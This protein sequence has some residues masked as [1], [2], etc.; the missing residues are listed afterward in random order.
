M[1]RQA[2]IDEE[3]NGRISKASSAFGR[4][5]RNVWDRRGIKLSTKLKVYQA[6]VITTLLYACETWTVYR[7]HAKQLNHFHTTCLRRLL[8]IHWQDHTP[9]TEVLSR[10]N[11]PS[12]H[13]LIEKAQA[14]WAGHVRR[15]ND[16]RIPKMLLY[17]E[18]A[19][20]KRLAGRPKLRFK[21]SLKATLKSL[22]I[23]VENWEDAATDRHQWRRLVHQGAEL[24][25][26]R[27]ISLAVSKREARKA[28]EKNPSLQPLPEHKCDVCGRC[29]RARI[30]LVSHTRTHKD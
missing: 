4:L 17:G 29:F 26:R 3:V 30:G 23:P 8:K 16:S 14:R 25:E 10:A 1:S 21:D 12:I 24:A 2:N 18:L 7:R 22:S 5:R 6:V 15:M 11:M 9:D 27:R 13:T 19:E 28:R 20:G